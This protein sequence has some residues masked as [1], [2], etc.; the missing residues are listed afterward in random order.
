MV[1]IKFQYHEIDKVPSDFDVHGHH[2]VTCGQSM[3]P[4][5]LPQPDRFLMVYDLRV[6]LM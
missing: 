3:R 2:L 6:R 5:G 4:G 1:N